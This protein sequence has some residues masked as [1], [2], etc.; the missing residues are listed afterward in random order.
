MSLRARVGKITDRITAASVREYKP[1]EKSL[2][3]DMLR[4]LE[5]RRVQNAIEDAV[6][7]DCTA[8]GYSETIGR[9]N[10]ANAYK[11]VLV[12]F[13]CAFARYVAKIWIGR[14]GINMRVPIE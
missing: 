12:A 13:R 10:M 6:F 9:Q 2:I 14:L 11:S 7:R 1:G 4:E 5:A 8:E 3:S